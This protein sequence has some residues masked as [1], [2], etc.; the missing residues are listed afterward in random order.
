MIV[1]NSDVSDQLQQVAE[2]CE[3]TRDVLQRIGDKWTVLVIMSLAGGPRRFSEIAR[4]VT[5]RGLERDG[6]VT[7][8]VTPTVPARV[9]YALTPLGR[10]LQKPVAALGKWARAHQDMIKAARV[11]FDGRL[12]E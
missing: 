2:G 1:P 5:L 8:T 3:I 11:A 7:R 4:L 12:R 10:S 9:D 6:L